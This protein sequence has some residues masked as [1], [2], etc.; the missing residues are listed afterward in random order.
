MSVRLYFLKWEMMV[1]GMVW[2]A[3]RL[4][5][6]AK[7]RCLFFPRISLDPF[8]DLRLLL[9]LYPPS[10]PPPRQN[11]TARRRTR[12]PRSF[13]C[14]FSFGRQSCPYV[15]IFLELGH[16]RHQGIS[17]EVSIVSDDIP[18]SFRDSGLAFRPML[19]S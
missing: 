4:H 12:R 5:C 14:Q 1:P 13:S 11:H 16:I 8:P 15:A 9:S 17:S 2:T 7:R 19:K 6:K 10:R 3:V 18:H